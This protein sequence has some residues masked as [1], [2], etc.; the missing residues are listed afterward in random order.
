MCSFIIEAGSDELNPAIVVEMYTNNIAHLD[1]DFVD[2]ACSCISSAIQC[3][4]LTQR[5]LDLR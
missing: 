5:S 1:D 3:H 4:L 2:A